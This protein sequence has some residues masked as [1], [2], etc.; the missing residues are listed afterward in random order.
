MDIILNPKQEEAWK[1]LQNPDKIYVLLD[2]GARSGKSFVIALDII[3][4]ALDY[5]QSRH[6][7]SRLRF[8][9]AKTSI[10]HE[11]VKYILRQIPK[12]LWNENRADWYI[13]FSNGSEIWLG[14]FDQK[15]RTEK[16]LGHEYNT[17]YLN[18]V[19]Q[20]GYEIFDMA[21]PR[22]AKVNKGLINK[23]YFD[24]NPPSPLHWIHRVFYDHV[25]PK[26]LQTLPKQELYAKLKLNPHDNKANL[27]KNYIENILEILPER[28]KRRFLYGEYVKAEG[29][30]YERFDE[31]HIIKKTDVPQIEEWTVGVDFGLHMAA[32][33]I[34]WAGD[35]IYVVDDYGEFNATASAFNANMGTKFK[36]SIAEVLRLT[37]YKVIPFIAYCDPSGGERL[38]E[39]TNSDKANNSVD[40]GIDYINMKI[41][42]NEF[43]VCENCT[44]VLGEIYD[45][46]R[47]EKERIVKDNDHYMDGMRYGIFSR[48]QMPLQIF[49]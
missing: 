31:R 2:G 10:W 33:L 36:Q 28:A 34:G 4:R 38:Q 1:L 18:E 32:T 3:Q 16:I 9:H 29:V 43:F 20:L 48:V 13:E 22:L 5:P 41:E 8:N 27:P 39:I 17:V 23:A 7:I 11:T 21:I 12:R 25:D 15:E 45:Y 42:R 46:R 26:T 35:K 6:L 24:C 49:V 37:E 47:D 44:G 19:S 30:I 40:P 14:G